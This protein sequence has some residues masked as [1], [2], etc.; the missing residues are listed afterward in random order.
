M[1]LTC[2]RHL[3]ALAIGL[4][5]R[6]R[7]HQK[8]Q[9]APSPMADSGSRLSPLALAGGSVMLAHTA[10]DNNAARQQGGAILFRAPTLPYALA[11]QVAC[12]FSASRWP[13]SAPASQAHRQTLT[14]RRAQHACTCIVC[15]GAPCA[16]IPDNIHASRFP[17]KTVMEHGQAVRAGEEAVFAFVP[18]ATAS[19]LRCPRRLP[20]LFP[21]TTRTVSGRQADFASA[22]KGR[23][24][25]VVSWHPC[26]LGSPWRQSTAR[27]AEA[28]GPLLA[29]ESKLDDRPATRANL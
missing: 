2:L 7:H 11:K 14:G 5:P 4:D 15:L 16:A 27:R 12:M 21:L 26:P 24:E 9:Q 3:L 17:L 19:L 13:R 29:V 22:S 20:A 10:F 25:G 1:P 28:A 6:R 23:L 18:P 8:G